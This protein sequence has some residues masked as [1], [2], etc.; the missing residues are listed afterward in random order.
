[1]H[2]LL[3]A[4]SALLPLAQSATTDVT[5]HG[6]VAASR[7]LSETTVR[8]A[9]EA[10]QRDSNRSLR[11]RRPAGLETVDSDE[12]IAQVIA[13]SMGEMGSEDDK[14]REAAHARLKYLGD[15]AFEALVQGRKSENPLVRAWSARLLTTRGAKAVPVLAQTLR[16]D[17][18][19]NVRSAAAGALGETF[20]PK[21]VPALVAALRDTKSSVQMRAIDALGYLRG[22][23]AFEPLREILDRPSSDAAYAQL[24]EPA[25]RALLC[26]DEKAGEEAVR[27]AIKKEEVDWI[28]HNLNVTIGSPRTLYYWPPELLPLYQLVRDAFT[29]AGEQFGEAEIKQLL[30]HVDSD[31][32]TASGA[33]LGTL[34]ELRVKSAVP[35][36]LSLDPKK[37]HTY[38]ALAIF[39]T[40]EAVTCLLNAVQSEDDKTREAAINSMRDNAGRWAVPVLIELL[41]DP[42]L[43]MEGQP[44]SVPMVGPWPDEHL[45]HRALG[46]CLSHA[47]L[48]VSVLNLAN[49]DGR[50]FDIDKEIA[51]VKT[52]WK[53]YGEDFLQG[54][55]VPN[56]NLTHVFSAS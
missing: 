13:K 51:R 6:A 18:D 21:A 2:S 43:R 7:K 33:C 22:R 34:A 15:R 47:G 36:I 53:E 50:V 39:A 8:Q 32:G 27:N 5:P 41:D 1:M 17:P 25:A 30:D 40:P 49:S 44:L 55:P 35:A 19:E 48:K 4:L 42:S 23:E 56:P 26:I 10:A 20:D 31:D 52:W 11:D 24:R 37:R 45:A 38:P 28:R 29:L 3:I 14:T 12:A 9:M 54:K 46:A 16:D